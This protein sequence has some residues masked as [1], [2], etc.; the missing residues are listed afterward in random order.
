MTTQALNT[1]VAQPKTFNRRASKG[2]TLIELLVV[3]VIIGVLGAI[4][5]NIIGGSGVAASAKAE[6]KYEA[7]MKLVNTWAAVAQYMNV[8]KHPINSNLFANTAH[9]ALDVLI[10]LDPSLAIATEFR[11]KY[12]SGAPVRALEQFQT[13]TAPTATAAGSYAIGDAKNLVTITYDAA[14]QNM[15]VNIAA[16]PAEEV[17]ALM[18]KYHPSTGSVETNYTTTAR[19]TSNIQYDAL[20]PTANTHNLRIIRKI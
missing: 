5:N 11:A 12:A 7:S 20:N 15:T 10:P 9:N 16:V 2:F 19:S 4:I 18:D 14:T 3:I 13:V 6:Q 1:N 17:R 8:S